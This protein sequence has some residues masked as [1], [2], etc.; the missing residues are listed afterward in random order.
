MKKYFLTFWIITCSLFVCAQDR[1]EYEHAWHD[2]ERLNNSLINDIA[3]FTRSPE[4]H[5]NTITI[6]E[7]LKLVNAAYKALQS[8][9]YNL[10]Q[11]WED[12]MLKAYY[13]QV[14]KMQAI[15]DVYE[16]LLRWIAGYNS[17][18]IDGPEMELLLDPLLIDS[19]WNKKKLNIE[20]N[21][22]YFVEYEYGD[23]KMMFIKSTLPPNDY[24]HMKYYNIEVTFTFE[25]YAGGGSWY[26]GGNKYRMIQFKDD[27]N[28]HYYRVTKA[29]SVRK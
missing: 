6:F 22:A 16:E 10:R 28:P 7:H 5:Q 14:D 24:R 2:L 25:N 3:S 29:E 13:E 4:N 11:G 12:Y 20:C 26:I 15:A 9:K 1:Q 27:E 17:D 8:I 18:G 21:D 23:F 19:G